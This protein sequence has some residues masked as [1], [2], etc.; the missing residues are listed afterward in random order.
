M[1]G[2]RVRRSCWRRPLDAQAGHRQRPRS[3]SPGGRAG[4][5]DCRHATNPRRI[6]ALAPPNILLTPRATAT[7]RVR[8]R[9]PGS[10]ARRAE[11]D[12]EVEPARRARRRPKL[13]RFARGPRSRADAPSWRHGRGQ[14]VFPLLPLRSQGPG[15]RAPRLPDGTAWPTV[16]P[17]DLMRWLVRLVTPPG[18]TV[19]DPFAGT[20][21]TGQAADLEASGPSSSNATRPPWNSSRS[22]CPRPSSPD[23]SPEHHPAPPRPVTGRASTEPGT[24]QHDKP[25]PDPRRLC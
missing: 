3:D 16:K 18:G 23:C 5:I 21:T 19:L 6:G 1:D 4:L 9:L 11:R 7:W 13:L 14:Q 8:S 2:C 17:L 20:G 25:N 10:R 24:G 15:V 22:A 12:V